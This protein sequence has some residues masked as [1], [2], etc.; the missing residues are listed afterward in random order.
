[1]PAGRPTIWSRQLG[2]AL[3]NF[4]AQGN[5][6]IACAGLSGISRATLQNWLGDDPPVGISADERAEFLADYEKAEAEV[7]AGRVATI[8]GA[9]EWTSKAWLLERTRAHWRIP[10]EA[11]PEAPQ[12]QPIVID[13]SASDRAELERLRAAQSK[14]PEASK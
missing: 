3:V 9:G 8:Q 13:L 7:E 12:I 11:P 14:P 6:R 5:S 2:V 1:M 10:K 4:A